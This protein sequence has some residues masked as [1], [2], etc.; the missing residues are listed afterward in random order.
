MVLWTSSNR[1]TLNRVECDYRLLFWHSVLGAMARVN[2]SVHY[3]RLVFVLFT[4]TPIWFQQLCHLGLLPSPSNAMVTD[5]RQ[6][7]LCFIT[8]VPFAGEMH[9]T[10]A[11]CLVLNEAHHSNRNRSICGTPSCVVCKCFLKKNLLL[12]RSYA[13]LIHREAADR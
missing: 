11:P 2:F 9:F 8:E 7:C 1:N 5:R 13:M 3:D 12:C 4:K 6:P 10:F